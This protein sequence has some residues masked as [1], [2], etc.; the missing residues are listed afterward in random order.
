MIIDN[1]I[2]LIR[3]TLRALN[4]KN[5]KEFIHKFLIKNILVQIL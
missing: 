2:N 1:E 5:L 3:Q 4:N